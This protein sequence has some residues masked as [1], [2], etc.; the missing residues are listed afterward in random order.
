MQTLHVPFSEFVTSQTLQDH[1]GQAVEH[2]QYL[3]VLIPGSL[4]IT[5]PLEFNTTDQI[6]F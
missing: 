3:Q 5:C 2:D 4:L 1:P 6:W